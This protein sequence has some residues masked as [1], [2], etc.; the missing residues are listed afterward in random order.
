LLTYYL[1]YRIPKETFQEWGP[2]VWF[3]IVSPVLN[4]QVLIVLLTSHKY[5]LN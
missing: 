4:T 5:V 2:H 3:T 1:M